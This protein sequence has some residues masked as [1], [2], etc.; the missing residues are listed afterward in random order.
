[1][2]RF[3]VETRSTWIMFW[4][5]V[6]DTRGV[7]LGNMLKTMKQII[8]NKSSVRVRSEFLLPSSWKLSGQSSSRETADWDTSSGICFSSSSET[9]GQSVGPGEKAP[10]KFSSTGG[11][12]HGYRLSK[13]HFQTVK[14]MLAPDWAQKMLCIIVTNRQT[15]SP[16][17]F[18]CFWTRRLLSRHSCPPDFLVC[19]KCYYFGYAIRARSMQKLLLKGKIEGTR[20]R[21]GRPNLNFPQRCNLKV[22]S[23]WR[24]SDHETVLS[25]V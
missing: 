3:E 23:P 12:A 14:R 25:K 22:Y 5:V 1:M 10:R 4:F 6:V 11:R 17:F 21:R 20:G 24:V 7:W 18:S 8:K 2:I 13:D 9:Q 15:V 19:L 16:E